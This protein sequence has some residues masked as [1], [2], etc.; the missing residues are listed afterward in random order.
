MY[1]DNKSEIWDWL[2]LVF[3]TILVILVFVALV[4]SLYTGYQA[5]SCKELIKAGSNLEYR[6]I[7]GTC[8][9]KVNGVWIP[10]YQIDYSM[11][12]LIK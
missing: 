11:L 3:F 10:V 9:A 4:M 8:A 2:I 1:N 5:Y 7:A 6:M 12:Q